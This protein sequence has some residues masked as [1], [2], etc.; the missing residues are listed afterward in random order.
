M[1]WAAEN[2]AARICPGRP[3]MNRP[4]W[5]ANGSPFSRDSW[6]PD[7]SARA[8]A[9]WPAWLN[10]QS[11]EFICSG[12]RSARSSACCRSCSWAKRNDGSATSP[13]RAPESCPYM[14]SMLGPVQPCSCM[15]LANSLGANVKLVPFAVTFPPPGRGLSLSSLANVKLAMSPPFVSRLC[16][17]P[18]YTA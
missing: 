17:G 5:T 18:K 8:S 12:P 16:H 1:F 13:W 11:T 7:Q 9:A 10:S 3:A 15:F 2:G 14:S 6:K 4:A